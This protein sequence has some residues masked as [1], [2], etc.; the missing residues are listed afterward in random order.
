MLIEETAIDGV[1]VLSPRPH[2]DGR[3]SFHE[4]MRSS[5][6]ERATGRPFTPRQINF[7]VSRANTLRGIHG[8]TVPPG[9]VKYVTCVRGA[10]RDVV[11]DLRVGSPTFG[12]SLSNLL[13]PV[14]GRCV[15]IPDGVGHGFLSLTDDTCICYVLSEEFVPG[16]QIDINPMDPDLAIAWGHTR[17]PVIS[18]KDAGAIGVRAAL[19]AGLLPAWSQRLPHAPVRP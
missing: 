1:L 7:S 12:R 4:V 2:T 18:D 19:A 9:Q 10:L 14:N 5:E 17:P 13:D 11:V 3:G 6:V 15:Y 16:T 8:T